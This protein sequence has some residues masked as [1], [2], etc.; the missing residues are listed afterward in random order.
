M[1]RQVR[2]RAPEWLASIRFVLAKQQRNAGGKSRRSKANISPKTLEP[3]ATA[4]LYSVGHSGLDVGDCSGVD[5]WGQPVKTTNALGQ[6]TT[7]NYDATTGLP[8]SVQYPT[9]GKDSTRYNSNGMPIWVQSG[10]T[11]PVETAYN[12]TWVTQ[13]DSIW[14]TGRPRQIFWIGAYGRVDSSIVNTNK[15]RY[16]YDSY[17]RVDYMKDVYGT[18][19][20]D[21]TYAGTNGNLSKVALPGGRARVYGHDSYGRVT[22]DSTV[23]MAKQTFEYDKI[24]RRTKVYDGVHGTPTAFMARRRCSRTTSCT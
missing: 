12:S 22:S 8:L 15:T 18:V 20:R 13:P 19:V 2:C 1:T 16:Y 24:N 6:E 9:G 7:I 14:G 4:N 23:G 17:G 11:T 5:R 3:R 21:Y 10:G